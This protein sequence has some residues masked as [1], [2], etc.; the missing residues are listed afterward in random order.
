[1]SFSAT[2]S[3]LVPARNEENTIARAI[4]SLAEQPE[5]A[6]IVVVDDQSSD[7]TARTLAVLAGRIPRVRVLQTRELPAGWVGK[8][9]A[10]SLGA[11]Q[12]RGDWLLFTDADAVHLPGSLARALADADASGAAMV[13]YS[14]EQ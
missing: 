9:Y 5:I 12:A 13:S 6:E 1:M 14:P 8:N 7:G 3:A 4:E 11:A 2:V 10:L